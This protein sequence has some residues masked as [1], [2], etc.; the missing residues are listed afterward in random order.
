L[1]RLSGGGAV[2]H[3]LGN[4]NLSFMV[5]KSAYAPDVLMN[6][7][8]T[9]LQS[10]SIPARICERRS[11]W[12]GPAKVGGSAFTLTGKSA[13]LHQCLLISAEI[14]TLSRALRTPG[15][16]RNGKSVP[17]V[18]SP[19]RNL[20]DVIPGLTPEQVAEALAAVSARHWKLEQRRS[21]D[22]NALSGEERQTLLEKYRGWEWTFG[23]TGAFTHTLNGKDGRQLILEVNRGRVTQA[24]LHTPGAAPRSLPALDSTMYDGECLVRQLEKMSADTPEPVAVPKELRSLLATEIPGVTTSCRAAEIARSSP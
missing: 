23:R 21:I 16:Q 6:L 4:L 8:A 20:A 7:G 10:L 1:R 22:F 9:A 11:I 15:Y 14:N 18:R 24:K 3:D 2:Y 5:P 13:L 19:V 12:V 17:S